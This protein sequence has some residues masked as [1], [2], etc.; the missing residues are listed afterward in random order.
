MGES[1]EQ[2]SQAA[3]QERRRTEWGPKEAPAGLEH[4]DSIEVEGPNGPA[5]AFDPKCRVYAEYLAGL[6]DRVQANWTYPR[7][8]SQRGQA[9][10]GEARFFFR[11]NGVVQSVVVTDP[12]A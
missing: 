2:K 11:P 10:Q 1:T 3:E 4:C 7:E 8:A 12:M 5:M 6:K 9:G